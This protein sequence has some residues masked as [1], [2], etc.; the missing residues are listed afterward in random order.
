[1]LLKQER[2]EL[3]KQV[4]DKDK[5]LTEKSEQIATLNTEIFAEGLAGEIR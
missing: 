1:M 5:E 3:E 4:E 2:Y